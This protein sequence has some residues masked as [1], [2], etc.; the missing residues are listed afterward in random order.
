MV[1]LSFQHFLLCEIQDGRR[2][3]SWILQYSI[4]FVFVNLKTCLRC[5]FILTFGQQIHSYGCFIIL[6]THYIRI[7]DGRRRPSWILS[8][9]IYSVYFNLKT[10]L[11]CHFILTLCQQIRVF[12][13][14]LIWE[15]SSYQ[16]P[17]SQWQHFFWPNRFLTTTH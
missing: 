11:R 15:T 17:K 4:S 12:G 10:R 5:H 6:E 7:Q 14:F 3:P 13:C 9:S 16:N 1:I 8:F 2:W